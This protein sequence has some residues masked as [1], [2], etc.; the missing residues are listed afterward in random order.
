MRQS[1]AQH[2]WLGLS[3]T[4][5][6]LAQRYKETALG[7]LWPFL[8]GALLLAVFTFV[9]SVVL[10]V[11]WN[12]GGEAGPA[13]GAMMIMGGLVPYLFVAETMTRTPTAI[14]SVPNFVKKI[15]FPLALL[16]AVAVASATV[17]LGINTTLLAAAVAVFGD[18]LSLSV[19]GLPLIVAPLVL[20]ALGIAYF[21]SA[22]G[23]FFR[24]LAQF[25]PLLAQLIMFLAP[26]CYPPTAVPDAFRNVI[27][28]N[29]ITWFVDGYRAT[30]LEGRMPVWSGVVEQILLWAVFAL[31]GWLFFQRTRRMFGDLL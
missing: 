31:L 30:L 18:G 13:E 24:D 16:P 4:R 3:L 8:Y 28:W 20:F 27:H 11:R 19:L 23:V 10:R 5:R 17:I 22:L 6:D 25:S 21:F 2:W 14:V 15:R 1:L 26:V 29:P 7:A 12:P 9:F